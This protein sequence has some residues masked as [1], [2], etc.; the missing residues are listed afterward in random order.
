MKPTTRKSI[1]G[2]R[3]AFLGGS[4]DH[5][6]LV[7]HAVIIVGVIRGGQAPV[8]GVDHPYVKTQDE[9][10]AVGGL[11][12]AAD[13]LDVAPFV[14]DAAAQGAE[15]PSFATSDVRPS[16]LALF[17]LDSASNATGPSRDRAKG[18][19]VRHVSGALART[20]RRYQIALDTL[21]VASLRE[22]LRLLRDLDEEKNAAVRRARTEPWRG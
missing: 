11:D 16:D 4:G 18:E 13:R 21:D 3:T 19:L 20:G 22:M 17:A 14:P 1:I 5:P 2:A 7:G 6:Y 15:R 10:D 9:L 8:P 12:L